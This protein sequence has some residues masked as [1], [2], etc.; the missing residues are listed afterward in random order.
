MR[1]IISSIQSGSQIPFS[2]ARLEGRQSILSGMLMLLGE[3][4]EDPIA[5]HATV[6]VVTKSSEGGS[7]GKAF[8]Q[9]Q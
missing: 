4:V 2:I 6:W 7:N 8:Q 5:H 1:P 9:L 3:G